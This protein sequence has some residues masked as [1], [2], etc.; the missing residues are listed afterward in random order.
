MKSQGLG[1][2]K[3]LQMATG[4]F[5]LPFSFLPSK[6]LPIAYH[7][8]EVFQDIRITMVIKT[9]ALSMGFTKGQ[10]NWRYTTWKWHPPS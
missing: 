7:I 2:K 3:M 9:Q 1:K 6:H 8:T 4:R 5:F 10:E